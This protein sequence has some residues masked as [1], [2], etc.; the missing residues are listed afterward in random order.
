ML[1]QEYVLSKYPNAKCVKITSGYVAH[2]HE[3]FTIVDPDSNKNLSP[4][5]FDEPTAWLYAAQ[6]LGFK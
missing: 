1:S 6:R 4:T 3:D 5:T 2:N